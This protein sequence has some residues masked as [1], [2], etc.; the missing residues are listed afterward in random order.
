MLGVRDCQHI[1]SLSAPV[2]T[3]AGSTVQAARNADL[4]D[5]YWSREGRTSVDAAI[6]LTAAGLPLWPHA[7]RALRR[8]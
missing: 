7:R 8:R 1:D 3:T 2:V 5:V 4:E 6:I